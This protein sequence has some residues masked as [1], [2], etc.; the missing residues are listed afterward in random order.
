MIEF[1]LADFNTGFAIAL[2]MVIALAF[3]E[4]L[5][6]LIGLSLMSLLDQISPIEFDLEVD[7]E[8][9]HGGLT[10]ILGWLCLNR[11][12]LLIWLVL[13]LTCFHRLDIKR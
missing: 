10:P 13:F 9:S 2:G 8:F 4:G 12:P 5:G 3:L 7:A 11:L 6:M 1:L